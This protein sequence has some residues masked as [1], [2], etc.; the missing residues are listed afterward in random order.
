MNSFSEVLTGNSH[1]RLT[2]SSVTGIL[3]KAKR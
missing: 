1:E 2:V 3:A